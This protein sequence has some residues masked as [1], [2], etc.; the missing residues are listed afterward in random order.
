MDPNDL[1]WYTYSGFKPVVTYEVCKPLK[2]RLDLT[3]GHAKY[4]NKR[5]L[6]HVC[7]EY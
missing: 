5:A 7:N 1:P 6:Y 3:G 2:I 4:Q